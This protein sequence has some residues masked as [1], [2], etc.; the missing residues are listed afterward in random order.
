MVRTELLDVCRLHAA[1][2]AA[3]S[4]LSRLPHYRCASKHQLSLLVTGMSPLRFDRRTVPCGVD[5]VRGHR[6]SRGRQ[7]QLLETG[8][9][10]ERVCATHLAP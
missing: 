5:M 3:R 1:R 2:N 8:K 4:H 10:K 9:A 6:S 7:S